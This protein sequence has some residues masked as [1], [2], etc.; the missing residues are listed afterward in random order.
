MAVELMRD[1]PGLSFAKFAKEARTYTT[2]QVFS[3]Y[4]EPK[5]LPA[6]RKSGLPD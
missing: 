3:D 5:L 6:W 4:V 2:P 1:A